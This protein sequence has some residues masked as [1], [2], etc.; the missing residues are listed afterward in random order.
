MNIIFAILKRIKS[1]IDK[2]I[3]FKLCYIYLDSSLGAER[4][5]EG[6][7]VT[8]ARMDDLK[9]LASLV[10]DKKYCIF[11][12]RMEYKNQLYLL[13]Y[14]GEIVGYRWLSKDLNVYPETK[15]VKYLPKNT[16]YAYDAF[17]SPQFRGK[18]LF[19]FFTSKIIDDSIEKGVKLGSYS[20]FSNKSAQ[21]AKEK[22][23]SRKI[24]LILLIKFFD[25][26][27]FI[28]HV[29]SY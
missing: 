16:F 24:S 10:D 5:V 26:W 18:G 1:I 14:K 13:E 15:I 17:I 4:D 8:P 22:Q 25:R 23:D 7:T 21:R 12:K 9:R 19:G 20:D 29:K 6:F 2:L 28:K 11:K 27:E 3:S